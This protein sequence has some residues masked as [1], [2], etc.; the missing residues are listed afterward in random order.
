ML[1]NP[2]NDERRVF[3]RC[4]AGPATL[5]LQGQLVGLIKDI[6]CGGCAFHYVAS[7]LKD[8][9]A[10]DRLTLE[11]LGMQEVRIR[12]V[13]DLPVHKKNSSLHVRLRRVQFLDLT[14]MQM[15]RLQV[16]LRRLST[17]GHQENN[18]GSQVAMN[19]SL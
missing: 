12:M 2:L 10:T 15:R 8:A 17:A 16:Y 18:H 11:P 3:L 1:R 7:D 5:V 14:A 4:P 9:G 19:G 13:D 6:S